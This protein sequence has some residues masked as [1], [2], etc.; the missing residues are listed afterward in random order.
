MPNWK[1]VEAEVLLLLPKANAVAFCCGGFWF[2]PKVNI[3]EVLLSFA[4]AFPKV[5][6]ED[7]LGVPKVEDCAPNGDTL[8]LSL[9]AG[10]PFAVGAVP[11]PNVGFDEIET[12]CPANVLFGTEELK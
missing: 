5:G 1:G 2:A 4:L 10:G 9:N 7:T 3:P 8:L 6:V 11:M 12:F